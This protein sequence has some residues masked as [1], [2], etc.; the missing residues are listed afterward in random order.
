M[1]EIL[2][3]KSWFPEI[4]AIPWEKME[5]SFQEQQMTRLEAST[6]VFK[7]TMLILV[8][9]DLRSESCEEMLMEVKGQTWVSF[10]RHYPL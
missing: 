8:P 5:N 9:K 2:K 10:L 3:P 1:T 7:I 6:F 4:G